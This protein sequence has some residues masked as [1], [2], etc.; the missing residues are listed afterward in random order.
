MKIADL[1]EVTSPT[2][3][4]QAVVISDGMAKRLGIAALAHA[5]VADDVATAHADRLAAEAARDQATA[6]AAG[7]NPSPV[8]VWF[9]PSDLT[10]M[11]QERTGAAA[12]TAASIDGPVG[13]W[14]NKGAKGGWATAPSNA[15][16]PILRKVGS[17]YR[18]DFDGVD[19]VL[20][21]PTPAI[22]LAS[23]DLCIAVKTLG[24]TGSTS[25]ILTLA[26]ASGVDYNSNYGL[27]LAMNFSTSAIALFGGGT[28]T[29]GSVMV[30]D[31]N[32]IFDK[33][34][35]VIQ[36][37]RRNNDSFSTFKIDNA[38]VP[39]EGVIT[40]FG[41]QTGDLIIGARQGNGYVGFGNI[42]I[43]NIVI[44][45]LTPAADPVAVRSFVETG[46]Y[47]DL[48][49]YPA[50]A[51]TTDLTAARNTLIAEVFGVGGIPTATATK[52]VESPHPL[53][54]TTFTNLAQCE[55][56]T[57]PGYAARPR[58]WTPNSPRSDVI[59]LVCAGHNAGWNDNGIAFN[60]MQPLLTAGVRICTFVLPD[61]P[62][63]YTSG[64]PTSHDAD[65]PPLANWAGPVSIAINKLKADFP[66][67]AIYMTGIS[68]G[69]WTTTLCSAI[70]TRIQKSYQFVGSMPE[71]I[72]INRD[73]EQRL[74]G[75]TADFMTLYL[76]AA[77]PSPRRHLQVLYEN[78]PGGPF[79]RTAYCTRPPYDGKLSGMAAN[80][81]VGQ[82]DLKWV[83]YNLHA[84]TSA[85]TTL[86]MSEL[87]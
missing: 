2:G 73:Y 64:D 1:P 86:V 67:A 84:Y 23:I 53:T 10:T 65:Q 45:E 68:G 76:L 34:P 50:I 5:A 57:I 37:H 39:D 55:K 63:D 9:D 79:D 58:L 26:P 70:D 32:G 4:E 35:H 27:A 12:T 28:G 41:V 14:R 43:G 3:N 47:G 52:A 46:T 69:G 74:P 30:K 61:G 80:I 17:F 20:V 44:S 38:V 8:K 29:G 54:P 81:G 77:C 25:G 24:N 36:Y 85:F 33:N 6:A 19:D 22:N 75:L 72:Y 87:P 48:P 7:A 59:F 66:S 15:A 60:V 82:Y 49:N 42:S 11:K 71:F 83:N 18:L 78:D 62:N 51:D 31:G 21:L 13:S 16:R 40:G 56:M